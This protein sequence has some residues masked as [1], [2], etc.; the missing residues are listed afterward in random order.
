MGK[1]FADGRRDLRRRIEGVENRAACRCVFLVR[2]GAAQSLVFFAPRFIAWI[3]GLGEA[4]EAA[5]ASK[6]L[7]LL[8]ARRAVRLLDAPH[9]LDRCE[10]APEYRTLPLCC[11][12]ISLVVN[13]REVD[14]LGSSLFVFRRC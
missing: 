11:G 5:V 1:P 2:E 6:E 8:L 13:G 4:A 10:I 14:R 12:K 3:E 7:R 9:H